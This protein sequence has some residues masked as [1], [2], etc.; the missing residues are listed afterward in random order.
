MAQYN[1]QQYNTNQYN[2]NVWMQYLNLSDSLAFAVTINPFDA[3]FLSDTA[4]ASISTMILPEILR[5]DDW[6]TVERKK[7]DSDWTTP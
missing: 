7:T 1:T 6:L 3:V 4:D 2:T 5:I